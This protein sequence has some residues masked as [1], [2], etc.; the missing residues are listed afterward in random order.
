MGARTTWDVERGLVCSVVIPG[1][2]VGKG[3]PRLGKGRTYTP[4]QTEAAEV[5][6]GWRTKLQLPSG[7]EV[8]DEHEFVLD[9]RFELGNKRRR[10]VD[11]LVK[12]VMDALNE[13][14]WKDDSQVVEVH[15]VLE[16]GCRTPRTL[17]KV[18]SQ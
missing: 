17:F 18:Y 13:I 6:V 2:P 16:R 12:L 3:R 15:A 11:N 9:A 5:E 1:E 8:D 4:A 7:Y 10:D 14:V